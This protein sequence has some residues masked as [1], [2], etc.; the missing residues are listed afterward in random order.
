LHNFL[1]FPPRR[2]SSCGGRAE[3]SIQHLVLGWFQ[4]FIMAYQVIY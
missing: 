3:F 1:A 2:S 4:F